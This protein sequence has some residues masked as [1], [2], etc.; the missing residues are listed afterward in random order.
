M[1]RI[2][3]LGLFA[4]VLAAGC[5]ANNQTN[6]AEPRVNQQVHAQDTAA[7]I[8][9][10][11]K[12]SAQ[13]QFTPYFL[14]LERG[15]AGDEWLEL[16]EV[17]LG[18]TGEQELVMR[19]YEAEPATELLV[20]MLTGV[21]SW[22]GE[23]YVIRDLAEE[24]LTDEEGAYSA[25]TP[26][27]ICLTGPGSGDYEVISG[28][29]MV[30]NGPGR[31]LFLTHEKESGRLGGFEAWGSGQ[32]VPATGEREAMF[33]IF[34]PGLH[35]S[36]PDVVLVRNGEQGPEM[37]QRVATEVLGGQRSMAR[38]AVR[39]GKFLIAFTEDHTVETLETWYTWQRDQLIQVTGKGESND[40]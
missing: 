40:D 22:Q 12:E 24:I 23:S 2:F 28:I 15:E 3:H 10:V 35:L 37:S 34:M 16:G 20:R 29:A 14:P 18:K 11:R 33:A 39:E 21:L 38:L 4:L 6:E 13:L 5:G 8:H 31:Q 32:L 1:K 7:V 9:E 17:T 30:G 19:V 26:Y 25:V 36:P 27:N